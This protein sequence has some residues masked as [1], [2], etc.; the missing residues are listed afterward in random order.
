MRAHIL[1]VDDDA[2]HRRMLETLLKGWGFTVELADDG[3]TGV[4]AVKQ[5]G[6]DVVLMDMKMIKMSGMQA[7]EL[8]LEYNPALPIIIMTAYSSVETAVEALKTGAYDYLTKPLDFEK[9]KRTIER[10]MERMQLKSENMALKSKLEDHFDRHRIIGKSQ[11]IKNMLDT[12]DLVAPSEANVLITGESG[13]GKELVS[14]AIHM[15]SPR[16]AFPFVRINCAAISESLLESELFGHVKGAFTGAQKDRK[17]MFLQANQG[18]IL[19]DEIGEM[20][21]GMQA[22]LLRVLQ[23]KEI[24]PVGS[25]KN[26][27]VDVRVIASTNKDLQQLANENKFRED[28]YFRL[29]VVNIHIP[30]LNKRVEDIPMLSMYFLEHFSK[31]NN[32][33]I[34]GF[35]PSAMD[36]IIRHDWPG[37][38]RELMNCIERLVVLARSDYIMKEDL[39]FLDKADVSGNLAA[40]SLSD[41]PLFEVE[42]QA[43]L[44]TLASADGNRSEAARRLGI[45]RKTL[46][47]KLK[48]YNQV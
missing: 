48:Q 18:S 5:Q 11:S 36:A 10:I 27:K 30:P 20:A 31:K 40:Q 14:N 28:L 44:Q 29:N 2:A 41:L 38:V 34:Q 13:T 25:E 16:K 8:M 35:S 32:R 1:V 47:S 26:T 21:L 12:I 23:E 7:L 42:K 3:S 9:L 43:V 6:F 19:L 15:N 17:G 46:L 22:K 4:D 24:T 37:N 45:T 39:P 33:R